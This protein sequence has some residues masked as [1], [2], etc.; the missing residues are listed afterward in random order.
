MTEK[1]RTISSLPGV[2]QTEPLAKLLGATADHL[3]QPGTAENLSGYIG[4]RDL[5]YYDISKDFYI[6][7]SRLEREAHQLDAAMVSYGTD[8]SLLNALFYDDIINYLRSQG[9]L[10]DDHN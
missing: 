1:R 10:V 3:F 4:R 5:S 8:G 9:A 6:A 2:L 7:E